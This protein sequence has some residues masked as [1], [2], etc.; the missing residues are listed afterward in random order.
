MNL[1][2]GHPVLEVVHDGGLKDSADSELGA[3][4]GGLLDPRTWILSNGIP[5]G[6]DY[7]GTVLISNLV[8]VQISQV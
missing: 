8:A 2:S 7:S 6:P 3:H 5:G 4:T 1:K